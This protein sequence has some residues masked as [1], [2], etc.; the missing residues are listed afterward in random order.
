M[1]TQGRRESKNVIVKENQQISSKEETL[2]KLIDTLFRYENS[3]ALVSHKSLKE[4]P[5]DP[6]EDVVD[7]HDGG[8]DKNIDRM[9]YSKSK[10]DLQEQTK[11]AFSKKNPVQNTQ[12]KK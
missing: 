4:N 2:I 10:K 11:T 5:S 9:M 6:L 1:K 3:P 7:D 8:T 12:F